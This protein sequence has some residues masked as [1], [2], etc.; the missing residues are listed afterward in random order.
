[1]KLLPLV[2]LALLLKLPA[3]APPKVRVALSPLTRAAYLGALKAAV[4]TKPTMT[5]PVRKQKR[6]IVIPA[7]KGSVVF[8]DSDVDEEDPDWEE[9]TY[10]GYWPQFQFHLMRHNHYEWSKNVLVGRSGQKL[11]LDG[12]P[13]FSPDLNYFA[14]VAAG[15][16]YWASDNSIQLFRFEKGRWWQV[17]KLEPSI[18]PATWEPAEI[19]WLSNS[20]LLLKKRMWTGKKPGNTFAY[21]K[22][23]I[24]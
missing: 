1:M 14:A 20:T 23:E 10:Q 12:E 15:I 19:H 18:D 21:A 13:V 2:L 9:Y 22:L 6:R 5:F 24:H 16:E 8:K 7:A 17:W 4:D 3:G 11:E